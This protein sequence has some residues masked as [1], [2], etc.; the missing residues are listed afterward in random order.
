MPTMDFDLLKK[1][2][3]P[4][5]TAGWTGKLKHQE[6]CTLGEQ[7]AGGPSAGTRRHLR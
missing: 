4:L 2:K 6:Q 7:V 3:S 5:E 1:E